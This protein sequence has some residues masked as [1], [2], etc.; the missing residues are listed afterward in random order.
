MNRPDDTRITNE[1]GGQSVLPDQF[2]SSAGTVVTEGERRL[3]LAVLEDA[4]SA[5]RKYA[6]AADAK[7]RA[8]FREVE[9]WFMADDSGA[10]LDFAYVGEALGFDPKR[11]REGLRRWQEHQRQRRQAPQLRPNEPGAVGPDEGCT[12]EF[13]IVTVTGLRRASGE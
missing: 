5:F 9:E 8:L 1:A 3:L 6:T 7:G 12:D 13:T 4:V 11:V 2:F 10:T